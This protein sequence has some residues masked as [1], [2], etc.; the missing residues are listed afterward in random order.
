MCS[1]ICDAIMAL[2][3]RIIAKPAAD[4]V[5]ATT[6]IRFLRAMAWITSAIAIIIGIVV[7]LNT[8]IMSVSERTREIGIL[9]AIGWRKIRIVRMIL[10]EAF[11]MSLVGGVIGTAGAVGVTHLLG[12]HPAVAGLVDTHIAGGVLALW[13]RLRHVR[14]RVGRRRIRRTGRTTSADGGPSP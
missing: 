5:R 3:P 1:E 14:G 11:L 2:G 13:N 4:S 9:R 12:Q 8:M 10:V 6:E 7:M